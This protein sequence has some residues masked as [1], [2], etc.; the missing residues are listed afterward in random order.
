M[1]LEQCGKT[2]QIKLRKEKIKLGAIDQMANEKLLADDE[3]VE[4]DIGSC[5]KL[6]LRWFAQKLYISK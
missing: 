6:N 4:A 3:A 5:N 1:G 2:K